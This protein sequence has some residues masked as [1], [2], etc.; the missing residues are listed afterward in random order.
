MRND[1]FSRREGYAGHDSRIVYTT[2]LPADVREKLLFV[3]T[4]DAG[5]SGKQL[6][7]IFCRTLRVLATED[8]AFDQVKDLW[9]GAAW[10]EL[11]DLLEAIHDDLKLEDS[12]VITSVDYDDVGKPEP[13]RARNHAGAFEK[14]LNQSM[15]E[16][17]VGWQ[18]L[19]GKMRVRSGSDAQDDAV[20]TAITSLRDGGLP[21]AASELREAVKDL[22]PRPTVDL[23]GAVTHALGALE[24]ATRQRAGSNK[25]LGELAGANANK[26]FPPPLHIAVEKVYGYAS[27]YGRHVR[28]G[29]VPTFE[30]AELVVGLCAAVCNYLARRP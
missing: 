30:E 18:M 10:Y 17:G 8:D 21:T 14:E 4:Q 22:S 15:R 20:R 26:L 9:F 12:R 19:E 23:T 25:T 11:Y 24:A 7:P 29:G 27:N 1:R 2:E 13:V 3:L 28:E 16:L 6:R 5:Y